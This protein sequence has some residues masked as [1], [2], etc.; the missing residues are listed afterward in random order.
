MKYYELSYNQIKEII[1]NKKKLYIF[2]AKKLFEFKKNEKEEKNIFY[3][4]RWNGK[5][6]KRKRSGVEIF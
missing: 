5:K 6:E 4:A 2:K 1:Y 3:L